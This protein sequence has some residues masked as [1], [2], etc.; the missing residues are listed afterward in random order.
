MLLKFFDLL[1]LLLCFRVLCAKYGQQNL[2]KVCCGFLK[3]CEGLKVLFVAKCH[4]S[5]ITLYWR[6]QEMLMKMT[7]KKRKLYVYVYIIVHL[8]L[9]FS[10]WIF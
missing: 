2:C 8:F 4:L 1:C 5:A 7:S 3:Q 6:F 9:M 10:I